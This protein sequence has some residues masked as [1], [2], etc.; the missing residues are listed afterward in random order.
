MQRWFLVLPFALLASVDWASGQV[1]LRHGF[2]R[3]LAGN[4]GVNWQHLA[5]GELHRSG[6]GLLEPPAFATYGINKRNSTVKLPECEASGAVRLPVLMVDWED[7]EPSLHRSN[8]NNPASIYFDYIAQRPEALRAYLN[9]ADGPAAYFRDVSGGRLALTFDVYPWLRSA[10]PGSY[11]QPRSHYVYHVEAQDRFYCRRDEVLL[12]ALRDAIALHGLDP[13]RYDS[14]NN[15][16]I[17]GIVLVY[18]GAPGLC[19]GT[20]LSW[21][22]TGYGPDASPPQMYF[23]RVSELVAHSDSNAV[24]FAPY[25]QLLQRYNNIPESSPA[26]GF[27]SRSTWAHEL[28]HLLLGFPD[29]YYSQFNLG[30]WGLSGNHGPWPAHPA[31]FEKWLFAHWL[32]P[33]EIRESG[34]YELAANEAPS[35]SVTGNVPRLY[36]WYIDAKSG[37]YITI[38]NR[39][40]DDAGNTA[41]WTPAGSGRSGLIVVEFDWTADWFS[42]TPPQLYR[43]AS[44]RR[45]GGSLGPGDS[46]SLCR[47]SACIVID[48]ISD[49]GPVM[50]FDVRVESRGTA[51]AAGH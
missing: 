40:L 2:E 36:V 32:E 22:S 29:Y 34:R 24:L 12:D 7:F 47:D 45:S 19:S 28:G 38:E 26:G 25:R 31:A 18:E 48:N 23:S 13:A 4:C 44:R 9:G 11:L 6:F 16:V 35:S 14:D 1:L 15:G 46:L 42:N 43:H 3:T 37:R 49:V 21:L 27:A 10:A 51:V 41:P 30:A 17:D 50:T 8:E 20:N 5:S 39:W 33:V